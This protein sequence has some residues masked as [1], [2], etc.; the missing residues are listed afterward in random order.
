[1][2]RRIVP[3]IDGLDPPLEAAPRH[4]AAPTRRESAPAAQPIPETEWLPATRPLHPPARVPA[5]CDAKGGDVDETACLGT[6]DLAEVQ[7]QHRRLGRGAVEE[8][9]AA[10]KDA[11]TEE[12]AAEEEAAEAGSHT[13]S[14]TVVSDASGTLGFISSGA[15]MRT[16]ARCSSKCL[17]SRSSLESSPFLPFPLMYSESRCGSR[18]SSRA[19]DAWDVPTRARGW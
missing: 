1:M 14:H 12:E 9:A 17:E 11:A 15:A 2:M 4:C 19:R 7:R 3:R 18:S 13:A 8:E 10:E 6:L 5:D 16:S